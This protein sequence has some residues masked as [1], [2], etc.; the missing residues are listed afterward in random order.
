MCSTAVG[1]SGR[2]EAHACMSMI[3]AAVTESSRR[4]KLGVSLALG[5]FSSIVVRLFAG[6]GLMTH[7]IIFATSLG[8]PVAKGLGVWEG[9]LGSY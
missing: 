4:P 9:W 7:N 1:P 5:T 3:D 6:I 2:R 8:A